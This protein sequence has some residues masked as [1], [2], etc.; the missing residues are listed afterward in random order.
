MLAFFAQG[1]TITE[2]EVIT[3]VTMKNA[4]FLDV[5]PCGFIINPRFDE[6]S[7]LHLQDRRNNT[8]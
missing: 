8:S 3:A 4:I 1:T 6:T 2:F 5:A 7:R